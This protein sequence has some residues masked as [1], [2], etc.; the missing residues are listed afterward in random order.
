MASESLDRLFHTPASAAAFSSPENLYREAKRSGLEV[1]LDDVKKWL[2]TQ[3]SY[4]LHRRH[5][6]KFKRNPIVVYG[7]DDLWQADLVDL[8]E[9]SKKNKGFKYLFTCIDTFSKFA[10]VIPMKSKKTK[11]VCSAFKS[12]VN[13]GRIPASLQVDEGKE[14]TSRCF[15]KIMDELSINLYFAMNKKIKCAI[16]ERFHRTLRG[17][18]FKMFTK[19]GNTKWYKEI[20]DLVAGYNK[21]YHRSIKMA[22]SE[23][24]Y[25]NEDTVYNNL[26]SKNWADEDPKLK[27]GQKVR[28]LHRLKIFDRKYFPVWRDRHFFIKKVIKGLNRPIYQTDS[29]TLIRYPEQVQPISGDNYRI[30][31]IVGRKKGLVKVR[32]MDYPKNHDKWI[33]LKE[34]QR[35]Q[36]L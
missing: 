27:E 7:I 33:S 10:F 34:L 3:F 31:K 2:Q 6:E 32:W 30:E 21:S 17:R 4:T 20:Q 5:V 25:E 35:L 18:M 26:Y 23:V 15:K 14:F 22:P 24:N 29:D 16:V 12:I 8:R 19:R 1:T 9:F 28:V 13:K 36:K 11:S